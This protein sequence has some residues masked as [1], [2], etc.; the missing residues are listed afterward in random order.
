MIHYMHY[1]RSLPGAELP[2]GRPAPPHAPPR[3]A[4]GRRHGKKAR[5]GPCLHAFPPRTPGNG[6][7]VFIF[8][9]V[10][11]VGGSRWAGGHTRVRLPACATFAHNRCCPVL[12]RKGSSVRAPLCWL[13]G[14]DWHQGRAPSRQH[15]GSTPCARVAR[16]Q[17]SAQPLSAADEL[18]A[19]A[20]GSSVDEST[21]AGGQAP[22]VNSDGQRVGVVASASW[23]APLAG[24]LEE[25]RHAH[26]TYTRHTLTHHMHTHASATCAP[27]A[28]YAR[29][30][31]TTRTTQ[32]CSA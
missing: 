30:A 19:A 14:A 25:V 27:D 28:S 32:G 29:V 1:T 18:A 22:P 13:L 23:G 10:A 20:S 16:S 2:H 26:A 6:R 5:G 15:P 7:G 12:R 31:A 17:A 4:L 11:M 21:A 9:L 8:D 3:P 24:G